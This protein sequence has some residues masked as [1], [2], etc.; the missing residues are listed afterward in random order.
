MTTED[1]VAVVEVMM[2]GCVLGIAI[3]G[4]A[5]ML[6]SARSFVVARGDER[7]AV[8]LAQQKLEQLRALEF[9]A[10]P[11][12]PGGACPGTTCYNE[13]NLTAG[14]AGAAEFTRMT[15]VD[16]VAKHDL[17][18]AV[19]CP[20]PPILKRLTVT[21]TPPIHQADAIVLQTVLVSP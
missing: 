17:N 1:G 21:V 7:V 14:V 6:S 18:I 4:V 16:C 20:T 2:A 13:A 3:V 12:S 8:F 19:A 9:A 11:L 10:V 15:T 5:L